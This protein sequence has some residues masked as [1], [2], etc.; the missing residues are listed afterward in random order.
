MRRKLFLRNYPHRPIF[1]KRKGVV[2]KKNELSN[3]KD[4]KENEILHSVHTD[5][6]GHECT[7]LARLKRGV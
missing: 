3:N 5:G 7:S 1:A 4:L 6:I 2:S